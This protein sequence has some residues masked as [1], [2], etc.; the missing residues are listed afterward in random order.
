MNY[1]TLVECWTKFVL[2]T[3]KF[4]KI[5]VCNSALVYGK[6]NDT[7]LLKTSKIDW[8]KYIVGIYTTTYISVFVICPFFCSHK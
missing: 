5:I 7:D 8:Y 3:F 2:N 6:N 1:V 4:K